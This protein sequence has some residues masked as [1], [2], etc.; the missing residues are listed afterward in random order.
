MDVS[1]CSNHIRQEG[2]KYNRSPHILATP[3]QSSKQNIDDVVGKYY[4][5]SNDRVR[6]SMVLRLLAI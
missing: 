3:V 2:F 1:L 5:R 6:E 4:N